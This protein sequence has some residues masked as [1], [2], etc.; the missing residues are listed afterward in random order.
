MDRRRLDP[1][2]SGPVDQAPGAGPR[3]V[4]TSRP[5]TT[6][7]GP[8]PSQQVLDGSLTGPGQVREGF[9]D[10]SLTCRDGSPRGRQGKKF[11]DSSP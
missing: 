5:V 1:K 4:G 9:L 6:R 8:D 10:G 7:R 2:S 3:R 11:P